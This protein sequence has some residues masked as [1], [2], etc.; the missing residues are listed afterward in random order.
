MY[1]GVGVQNPTTHSSLFWYS[2]CGGVGEAV[3]YH[4]P[5]QS[6]IPPRAEGT[7]WGGAPDPRGWLCGALPPSSPLPTH[8]KDLRPPFPG[9]AAQ[10]PA[11]AASFPRVSSTGWPSSILSPGL[12]P[13]ILPLLHPSPGCLLQGALVASFFRVTTTGCLSS[14]LLQSNYYRVPSPGLLL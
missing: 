5:P 14:I 13:S 1:I 7:G 9:A 6:P 3:G 2:V 12:L 10:H 4:P 8:R 11:F